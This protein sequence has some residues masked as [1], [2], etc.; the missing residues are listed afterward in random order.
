MKMGHAQSNVWCCLV[1]SWALAGTLGA[2]EVVLRQ[3]GLANSEFHFTIQGESKAAYLVLE[4]TNLS[5]WVPVMTNA[6]MPPGRAFDFPSAPDQAWFKVQRLPLPLFNFAVAAKG[7]IAIGGNNTHFDSFDSSD[8]NLSTAGEYDPA[9]SRDA[10]DIATVSGA[11]GAVNIGNGKVF[12]HVM[13]GSNGTITLGASGSVGS[14]EW[15]GFGT[16]QPGWVLNDASLEFPEIVP[17]FT[18][19]VTPASCP[20]YFACLG[21]G[22]YQMSSLQ[23]SSTDRMY[24]AGTNTVLYV[25]GTLSMSGEAAIELA[26]GAA[27]KL[28]VGGS[29]ANIGGK[30]VINPNPSVCFVYFGLTNNTT[31]AVSPE[32]SFKGLIYAPN[33]AFSM[34]ASNSDFTGSIV[35]KNA[36]FGGSLRIHFDESL[37]RS[38]P[39]R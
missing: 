7:P 34:S 2:S 8:P 19:G 4:S 9:R 39:M 32:V 31:L 21:N 25:T 5:N 38:G 17:P 29:S 22:D 33:A 24:I 30:G 6:G 14:K 12:G 10:G 37:T 1:A 36:L 23:L 28:Y 18:N 16:V 26:P 20:G 15:L 11:A 13:T 27:L 35:C 3:P